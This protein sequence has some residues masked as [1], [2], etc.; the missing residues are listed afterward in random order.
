MYSTRRQSGTRWLLVFILGLFLLASLFIFLTLNSEPINRRFQPLP[1]Y[2]R[3]YINKFRPNVEMPAPPAAPAIAPEMLLETSGQDDPSAQLGNTP[4]YFNEESL[5]P[6][7]ENQD[8][9]VL[10]ESNILSAA[11]LAPRV[12]LTGITHQWQTWNN[13]GPSTITM[14]L[15]Y[16]GRPETQVESAQFLKPNQEDKNVSPEELAAYA[17]SLGFEAVTR[18]MKLI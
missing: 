12:A 14:N 13:C 5:N 18:V 6:G 10:V 17:R 8:T 4:A 7:H 9:V 16:Y 11:P 15:S 3:A 1:Y 2:V